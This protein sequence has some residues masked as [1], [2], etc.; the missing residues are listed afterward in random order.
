MGKRIQ[1]S[2][3]EIAPPDPRSGRRKGPLRLTLE[4]LDRVQQKRLAESRQAQHRL[5]KE[6]LD[7]MLALDI[8][9]SM[10][11]GD[12]PPSRLEAAKQAAMHFTTTKIVRGYAD[13]VGLLVF[14]GTADLVLSP[15]AELERVKAAIARVSEVRYTGTAIGLALGKAWQTLQALSSRDKQAIILLTDGEN[16]VDPAPEEVAQNDLGCPVYPIGL[17]TAGGAV[18]GWG[19][20][21]QLNEP[22]LV[23]WATLTGGSYH[24]A[25]GTEELMA[26]YEQLAHL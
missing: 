13:R 18:V 14:S 6:P 5:A 15:T 16:N 10:S 19:L 21:S 22:C 17:G 7:I 11:A 2:R 8:S 26:I 1:I 24:R 25:P 12:F 9:G 20:R 23:R 4:D 3:R